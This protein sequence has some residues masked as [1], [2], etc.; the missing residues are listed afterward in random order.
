MGRGTIIRENA[1]IT[2]STECEWVGRGSD[3]RSSLHTNVRNDKVIRGTLIQWFVLLVGLIDSS[4][5]RRRNFRYR[6]KGYTDTLCKSNFSWERSKNFCKS[7]WETTNSFHSRCNETTFSFFAR[8]SQPACVNR[9][10]VPRI[11]IRSRFRFSIPQIFSR[12]CSSNAIRSLAPMRIPTGSRDS[13]WYSSGCTSV[14][15]TGYTSDNYRLGCVRSSMHGLASVYKHVRS[16]IRLYA[17]TPALLCIPCHSI[18]AICCPSIFLRNIR[19][20]PPATYFIRFILA[21]R[22]PRVRERLR[23]FDR[24][25]GGIEPRITFIIVATHARLLAEFHPRINYSADH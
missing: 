24:S 23:L 6:D 1:D 8:R 11:E 17:I 21:V 14:S 13:Y 4:N 25:L 2:R 16:R 22:P 3:M 5:S 9:K 18:A 10:V 12:V 19:I 7:T 15:L 20:L